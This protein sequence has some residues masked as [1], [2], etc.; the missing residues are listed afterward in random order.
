MRRTEV[1]SLRFP[2]LLALAAV[3]VFWSCAV[4]PA[5]GRRE[6]SFVSESQEVEMGRS[7]D[8]AATAQFGGLYPDEGLQQ[9]LTTLGMD[10]ARNSERPDLPWSFKLVDHELINAFA[11]P[12]GFVYITRGILANMNSEAEL[13]G[14]LGHEAG[15]V[16]ARHGAQ[17]MTQQQLGMI[18]LL[19]G[20]IFSE[21]V[22]DNAGVAMQGLQLLFLK[23]GREDEAQSDRL[24]YRYMMRTG[25]DP[26]GISDVMRMLQS[27]SPSAEEMGIP[28]WM[29]SHPNPG[30]RVQANEQ[31]IAEET[32]D[33]S[34]LKL[35][36]DDFL[37]RLD[38]LVYGED[39]RQ[40]YFIDN[41]FIQ[42][43]LDF[44]ITFPAG[45]GVQNSPQAVQAGGPNQDVVM[46]VSFSQ[47]ATPQEAL[48]A[49]SQQ[50]GVT[51]SRPGQQTI[52]GLPAAWTD[53]VVTP[54]EG[55]QGQALAG[56]VRYVAQG[57]NVYQV[58]GYSAQQ[59]WATHAATVGSSMGTF[60][61]VRGATYKDV[62]P[63]RIE[64]V[65]LDRAMNGAQFLQRY[66]SSVEDEAVLLSNQITVDAAL[67]RGRLLKRITGGKVPTS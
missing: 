42:P 32:A 15:H 38:G 57:G 45:W 67:E 58:L 51:T 39:P 63:H 62:S 24:G 49:F 25:H 35:G 11:L 3:L 48:T 18:G 21:T 50:E 33:L 43:V 26:R 14:V 34:T 9:Y 5:T 23:Y 17:Q 55:Q 10:I 61:P 22:R 20:A 1:T 30:D 47:S 40:G 6:I 8:P 56:R 53:F 36:R 4:N 52:N 65:R 54:A 28:G 2:R 46:G 19:G 60:Q 7:S 29:L 44:E 16:T 66:P 31:R 37:R 27:T 13:V 59:G 64:I 12:G 41:R